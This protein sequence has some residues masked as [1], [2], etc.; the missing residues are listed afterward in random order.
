M[1]SSRYRCRCR[2]V[3]NSEFLRQ[4]VEPM[5]QFIHAT[6]RCK[7]NQSLLD[8]DP[9]STALQTLPH[10]AEIFV[11]VCVPWR[12]LD[13]NS[14]GKMYQKL[15]QPA[16]RTVLRGPGC[17]CPRDLD[18]GLEAPRDHIWV[19]LVLILALAV[20]VLFLVLQKRVTGLVAFTAA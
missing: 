18:L 17:C 3:R 9:R 15:S 14:G 12:L 10:Y 7:Q 19:V 11:E 1:P 2:E 16:S 5:T 8:Q 6:Q 4:P 13:L 20:A